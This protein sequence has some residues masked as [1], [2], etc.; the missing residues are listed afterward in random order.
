[1][2]STW[3]STN[4]PISAIS[5]SARFASAGSSCGNGVSRSQR[6]RPVSRLV[7]KFGISVRSVLST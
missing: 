5:S 1:M 4:S 2:G 7:R 6:T 3:L